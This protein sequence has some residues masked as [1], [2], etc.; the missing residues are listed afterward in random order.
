MKAIEINNKIVV[1]RILP[2]VWNDTTNFR[3]STNQ[4]LYDLGFRN[5]V[6]PNITQYQRIG[7]IFLDEINDVYTYTVIE[8]SQQEI[9]DFDDNLLSNDNSS[10]TEDVHVEKGK[11]MYRRLKSKI[12]RAKDLGVITPNQ[13]NLIYKPLRK[14]LVWL[15]SGDWDIAKDNLDSLQEPTNQKLLDILNAIKNKINTYIVNHYQ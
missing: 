6:I 1:Y 14:A 10:V 3:S 5:V 7:V 13:F 4:E 8:F 11:I 9:D 15:N 2:K 12:R